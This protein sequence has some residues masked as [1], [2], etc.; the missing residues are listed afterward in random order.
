MEPSYSVGDSFCDNTVLV[1]VSALDDN[2]VEGFYA[3]TSNLFSTHY[4]HYR[5]VLFTKVHHLH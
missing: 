1:N 4:F 5:K 2:L 3:T